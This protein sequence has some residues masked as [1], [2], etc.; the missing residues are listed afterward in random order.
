MTLETHADQRLD[1]P[2]SELGGK[3]AFSK[4]VQERVLAGD[5]D[6]AVHSAKDLQA[7]TPDGLALAAFPERGDP[8]DALIGCRLDE[9]P[10]GGH[11]GT[12]SN[13]RR[14][15]LAQLRPDLRF[16]G[17]RGNIGTRL[18]QADQF[19][20][21]VMAAVALERLDTTPDVFDILDPRTM[22]PQVGQ[23]A[24]AIECRAEDQA[25]M[26]RLAGIDHEPTRRVVE[27]ERDF[28]IELGGDC[29]LPA[30]AHAVLDGEG[31]IIDG[32]L[33]SD[34]E[35]VVVT[36][37]VVGGEQPGRALARSLRRQL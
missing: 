3:G 29:D 30:G 6:L 10:V 18:A 26:A 37:R 8:R 27:A 35:S 4:E 20:A 28:L 23:G 32:F 33:A 1:V 14:M 17:L 25:V 19:D 21:I 36:E 12:G 34:D 24:L 15:Q 22:I 11:V 2:I 9:L 31:L 5:A 7:V 13:R 16:S